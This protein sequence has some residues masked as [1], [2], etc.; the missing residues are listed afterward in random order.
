MISL[1]SL[2]QLRTLVIAWLTVWLLGLPLVHAHLDE[3][4]HHGNTVQ[5]HGIIH[6]IFSLDGL[7]NHEDHQHD[8]AILLGE[9]Q[10]LEGPCLAGLQ[11]NNPEINFSLLPLSPDRKLGKST[12]ATAAL[13]GSGS[14]SANLGGT[15]VPRMIPAPPMSLFLCISLPTRAPPFVSI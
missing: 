14:A 3:A 2:F 13:S 7:G 6:S 9:S 11:E 12:I 10:A 15:P 1:S 4:H 5:A 8:S